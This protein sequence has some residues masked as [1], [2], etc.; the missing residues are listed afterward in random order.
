[1]DEPFPDLPVEELDQRRE[2][3]IHVEQA[4][5]LAVQTERCSAP[6]FEQLLERA[7]AAG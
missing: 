2:E 3:P 7:N 1:M 5:G 4:A 6:D